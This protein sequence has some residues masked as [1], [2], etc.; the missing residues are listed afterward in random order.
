MTLERPN[1]RLKTAK[2]SQISM[3]APTRLIVVGI[4]KPFPDP[5]SIE[6]R[7]NRWLSNTFQ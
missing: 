6:F 5:T 1:K 3:I 7:A 2:T 4:T